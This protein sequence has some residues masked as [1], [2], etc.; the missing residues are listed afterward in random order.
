MCIH[1][2]ATKKREKIVLSEVLGSHLTHWY[3]YIFTTANC[4]FPKY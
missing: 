4:G 3:T 1:L 2:M